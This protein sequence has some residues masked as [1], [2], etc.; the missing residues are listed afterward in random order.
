VKGNLSHIDRRG[1][2]TLGNAKRELVVYGSCRGALFTFT[3]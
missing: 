1:K 2:S 3:Y